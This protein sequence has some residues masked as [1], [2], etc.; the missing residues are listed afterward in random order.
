MP[1]SIP[2]D[3]RCG[4]PRHVNVC[5]ILNAISY[6]PSTGCQWQPLPKDLPPK[7][8]AHDYFALWD[9]HATLERLH[10]AF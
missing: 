7:R 9:W 10:Y 8:T 4:R 2:P 1:I 3:K 5:E 6:L